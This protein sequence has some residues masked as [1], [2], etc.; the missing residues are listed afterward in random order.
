MAF[1]DA[2]EVL[3]SQDEIS[4]KLVFKVIKS[5]DSYNLD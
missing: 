2:S 4:K 3:K 1:E 5:I